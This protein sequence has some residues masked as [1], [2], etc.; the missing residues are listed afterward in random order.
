MVAAGSEGGLH[1]TGLVRDRMFF[2]AM[3]VKCIKQL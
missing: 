2:L 1:R 3:E